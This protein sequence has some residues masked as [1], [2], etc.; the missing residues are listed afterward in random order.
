LLVM[1][2]VRGKTGVAVLT[3]G[4]GTSSVSAGQW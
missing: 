2:P 1:L 4:A 3:S